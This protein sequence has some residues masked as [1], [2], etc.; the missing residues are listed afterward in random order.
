MKQLLFIA[1]GGALGAVCRFIISEATQRRWVNEFPVGT[2]T[3]N[4]IGCFLIGF[5]LQ[6]GSQSEW[7]TP[8]VRALLITGFLGA[9]TTFSTFGHDTVRCADDNLTHALLNIGAHVVFGLCA[10]VFGIT[11][12]RLYGAAP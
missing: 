9:L 7:L 10:V 6:L 2:L 4:L 1:L 5:L 8:S 12:A 11:I 3:V